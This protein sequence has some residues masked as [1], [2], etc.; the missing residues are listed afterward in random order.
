MPMKQIFFTG[1][2]PDKTLEFKNV[3]Y[4][5]GKL[6]KDR[7]TAMVCANMPGSDKLPVLVIGRSKNVKSLTTEYLANKK[8]WMTSS[9]L[10]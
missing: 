5:G 10:Y 2:L 9:I 6:S 3:S 8:A 7:L 4:H 1:L